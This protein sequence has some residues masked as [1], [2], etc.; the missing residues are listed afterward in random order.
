[1]V[2]YI[3]LL[4]CVSLFFALL[5]SEQQEKI[6]WAHLLRKFALLFVDFHL[7]VAFPK[8]QSSKIKTKLQ[9]VQLWGWGSCGIVL[10]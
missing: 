6:I 10:V 9:T 8:M 3:A 4:H 5:N 2:F 1:M 7:K